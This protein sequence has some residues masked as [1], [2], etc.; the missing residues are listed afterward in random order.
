MR[1][2]LILSLWLGLMG[3]NAKSDEET[4]AMK[5]DYLIVEFHDASVPPP[6]H[7]SYQLTF[8][9]SQVHIM[10][11]SYGD[12]LTNTSVDLGKEQIEKA[13]ELVKKYQVSNI[14]KTTEEEGCTGGTGFSVE[15]GLGKEVLCNGYNY[16]CGGDSYGD[17][18]GD[19]DALKTD[20]TKLIP[21]FEEYLKEE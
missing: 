9:G 7:R 14:E 16:F 8:E 21:N 10:V 5:I 20:L 2:L 18:T 13:F 12:V 1:W 15:Y 17:L 6:Y 3:C 11:D 4:T 19:L